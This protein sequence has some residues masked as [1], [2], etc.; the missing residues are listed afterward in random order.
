V[1]ILK[2]KSAICFLVLCGLDET[3][4]ATMNVL[5]EDDAEWPW[6]TLAVM[7]W[8]SQPD[9]ELTTLKAVGWLVVLRTHSGTSWRRCW[10][11]CNVTV[12]LLADC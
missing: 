5:D 1:H 11:Q 10:S 6:L 8:S 9:P 4:G 7:D 12:L 3:S 2:I